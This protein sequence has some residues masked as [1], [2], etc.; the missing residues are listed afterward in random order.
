MKNETDLVVL[1]VIEASQP[2]MAVLGR[3]YADLSD[4]LAMSNNVPR[5][6]AMQITW[7]LAKHRW[8]V[9]AQ[10]GSYATEAEEIDAIR[11][12]CG[13]D[14]ELTL[15][16]PRTSP[17]GYSYRSLS[18]WHWWGAYQITVWAHIASVPCHAA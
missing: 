12:W 14:D 16:E 18:A 13:R 10:L 3:I 15:S 4:W 2:D 6:H 5:L 17:Y 9:S 8:M 11:A 7:D 1:D